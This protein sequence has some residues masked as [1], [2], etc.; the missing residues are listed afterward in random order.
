M[1]EACDGVEALELF[2]KLVEN[3][4]ESSFDCIFMDYVMPFM[5]GPMATRELRSRGYSGPIIAVTGNVIS[6]DV[7]HFLASGANSVMPKPLTRVKFFEILQGL[8]IGYCVVRCLVFILNVYAHISH[9]RFVKCL[10]CWWCW[11]C[12]WSR[13]KDWKLC[14]MLLSS[15]STNVQFFLFLHVIL[16]SYLFLTVYYLRSV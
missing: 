15:N 5:D 8:F 2:E 11:W 3:G 12:W 14:F 16:P 4:D 6:Q 10:V 1:V 13:G 7:D 9:P